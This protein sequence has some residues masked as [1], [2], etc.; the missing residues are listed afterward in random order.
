MIDIT[1][2]ILTLILLLLIFAVVAR[3][4]INKQKIIGDPPIPVLFFILAKFC[5]IV[6]V[7]FLIMRCLRV[8]IHG[9]FVPPLPV[10]IIA[11]ILLFTGI[12]FLFLST[13]RLNKDLIF[14]LSDSKDHKLQTS[15]IY[16]LSRHPFY[17]GFILI[18]LSSCL[19]TPNIINIVAFTGAWFI[20]HFI[21][22]GEE[23]FLESV[24]G[25][26]Y[27]QYTRRVSRYMT[28]K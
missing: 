18:L 21:M 4:I 12:V 16:S 24:Y 19:F 26:E 9:L 17:L 28:F 11:L 8:S 6:N 27:R 1:V 14:G 2:I 22:T 7:A 10:E 25:E 5:V 23:K 3:A 13:F 15:G 20:H